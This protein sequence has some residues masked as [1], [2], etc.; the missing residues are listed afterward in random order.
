MTVRVILVTQQLV[1]TWPTAGTVSTRHYITK[2]RH[3]TGQVQCIEFTVTWRKRSQRISSAVNMCLRH[4]YLYSK[5]AS[6]STV[7]MTVRLIRELLNRSTGESSANLRNKDNRRNNFIRYETIG[8]ASHCCNKIDRAAANL[9]LTRRWCS[10]QQYSS[11]CCWK[12][13]VNGRTMDVICLFID[14]DVVFR[15][16]RTAPCRVKL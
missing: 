10:H 7:L 15:M 4:L 3:S 13:A 12:R 11:W 5:R 14:G 2:Q 1:A 8:S 9:P 6:W 16:P